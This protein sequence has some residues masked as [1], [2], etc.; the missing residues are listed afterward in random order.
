MSETCER[1]VEA[2]LP[3]WRVGVFVRTLHP[4]IFGRAFIW[5]PGA[6][7]VVNPADFDVCRTRRNSSSSPLA[8][9][10]DSGQEVRLSPRRSRE[11]A[12][13]R[14]STTCAPKVSPTISRCRSTFTD[15]S[16]ARLEL[17]HEAAGRLQRRASW[18]PANDRVA[19]GPARRDR[20]PAPHRLDACSTP[21]SATAPANASWAARSG[22]ATPTPCMRRSGCRTCAASPRCPTGC[23]PRPWS[24]SSIVISTARC[25]RSEATAARC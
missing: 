9:V 12:L 3:L 4:D 8:I 7:V 22:A 21:M 5:R 1:L 16:T 11:P 25:R 20:Q 10:Y 19:V 15:G 23:R 14:F 18:R 24:T 6:E 17:D 13:S 2:G